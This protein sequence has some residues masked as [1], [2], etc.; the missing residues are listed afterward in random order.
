[1]TLWTIEGEEVIRLGDATTHGGKVISASSNVF[2]EGIQIARVGD[3]VSCPLC[4]GTH[5]IVSGASSAFNDQMQIAR[6]GDSVSCGAKLISH[7]NMVNSDAIYASFTDI[8][9]GAGESTEKQYTTIIIMI[10]NNMIGHAGLRVD[11]G[12]SAL[13][14]DPAGSYTGCYKRSCKDNEGNPI[15]RGSGD[16]FYGEPGEFEWSDYLAYQLYDGPDVTGY[17]FEIP[18][19]QAETIKD[20]IIDTYKGRA[21]FGCATT[22][23]SLLKES[24]GVFA[25]LPGASTPWGLASD[26]SKVPG[27]NIIRY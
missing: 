17:S 24:G 9:T 4:K 23:S 16:A 8:V 13:L 5:T 20:L 12:D 1:M 7:G 2:Y 10:N 15:V 22:I 27:V 26:L 25:Q 14:Y 21:S 3:V 6:N 11:K 18:Q 19:S